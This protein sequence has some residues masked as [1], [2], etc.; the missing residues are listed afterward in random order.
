M[1]A[2]EDL[3]KKTAGQVNKQ[4][5]ISGCGGWTQKNRESKQRFKSCTLDT[6]RN[7]FSH[8]NVGYLDDL[9][10]R[11]EKK[12]W[13]IKCAINVL[14]DSYNAP[15]LILPITC[16]KMSC[17]LLPRRP[18]YHRYDAHKQPHC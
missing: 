13:L 1:G 3:K 15:A 2:D 14:D 9:L 8:L 4:G 12:I 6:I 17:V 7:Q 11:Q 16:N 5:E 10:K 18:A